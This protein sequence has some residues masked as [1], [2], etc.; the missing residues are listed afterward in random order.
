[1]LVTITLILAPLPSHL[2]PFLNYRLTIMLRI[3]AYSIRE[4]NLLTFI[5]MSSLGRS[6]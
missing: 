6:F 4:I 3:H 2:Y 1:M 5:I